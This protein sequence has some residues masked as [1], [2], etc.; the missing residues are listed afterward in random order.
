MSQ[1][2]DIDLQNIKEAVNVSD[3]LTDEEKSES[4]KRIEQWVAEDDAMELLTEQLLTISDNMK[5]LLAELGLI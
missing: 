1:S 4:F 2:N 3:T 5:S